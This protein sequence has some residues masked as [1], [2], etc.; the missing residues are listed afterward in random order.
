MIPLGVW[1]YSKKKTFG[2]LQGDLYNPVDQ[3]KYF[4]QVEQIDL[5]PTLSLLL[6]LPIPYNNLGF[7]IAE[8]FLGP[9][10]NNKERLGVANYLTAAQIPIH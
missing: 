5:V 8:A 10:S 3:G 4:R 6:G 1:L 2:R 7:P 9:K